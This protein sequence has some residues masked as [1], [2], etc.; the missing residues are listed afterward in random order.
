MSPNQMSWKLNFE[1]KL[2]LAI[3]SYLLKNYDIT[4]KTSYN[5]I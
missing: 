3:T 4:K 1:C 2:L 5:I